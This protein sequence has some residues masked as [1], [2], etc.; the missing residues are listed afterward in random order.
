MLL[1]LVRTHPEVAPLAANITWVLLKDVSY[2]HVADDVEHAI[3]DL[4]LD[5]LDCGPT[6]LGYT[7]PVDAAWEVLDARIKPF[8]ANLKRYVELGLEVEALEICKGIL[9]GLYRLRDADN[10]DILAHVPDFPVEA[11]GD[12]VV[13]WRRT[14]RTMDGRRRR[15]RR[16]AFPAAFVRSKIP[17]WKSLVD[18]M[19]R[20]R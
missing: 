20:R 2:E 16:P 4:D 6:P 8:L 7:E 9:L 3:L 11:A 14:Q 1:D 19:Q 13:T 17:Q 15:R 5:D 10:H 12:A 18:R